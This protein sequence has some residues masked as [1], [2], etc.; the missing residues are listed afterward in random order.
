MPGVRRHRRRT[1]RHQAPGGRRG[2]PHKARRPG[3]APAQRASRPGGHLRRLRQIERRESRCSRRP[4][5]P[6]GC[7][8]P[9]ADPL[10]PGTAA[11]GPHQQPA[12]GSRCG[13]NGRRSAE[14]HASLLHRDRRGQPHSRRRPQR[15]AAYQRRGHTHHPGQGRRPAAH[16]RLAAAVAAHPPRRQWRGRQSRPNGRARDILS[17]PTPPPLLLVG[18]VAL[19]ALA[20]SGCG[21]DPA[22]LRQAHSRGRPLRLRPR[23]HSGPTAQDAQ[24]RS[25][26]PTGRRRRCP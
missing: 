23:G 19:Q 10:H 2:A 20:A 3:T 12:C 9:E 11:A 26:R 21:H 15:L 17:L 6:A 25:A 1:R 24:T 16:R 22:P 13:G 4:L 7:R 8:G 14:E 18:H 5:G